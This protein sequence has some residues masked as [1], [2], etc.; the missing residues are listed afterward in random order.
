MLVY[1][2]E[3]EK[4]KNIKDIYFSPDSWINQTNVNFNIT[5]KLHAD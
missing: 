4:Q 3:L 2:E 5:L 1:K